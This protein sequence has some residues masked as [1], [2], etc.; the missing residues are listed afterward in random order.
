MVE[1][2]KDFDECMPRGGVQEKYSC[3]FLMALGSFL[4]GLE[5][6]ARRASNSMRKAIWGKIAEFSCQIP[7]RR[8]D[9]GGEIERPLQAHLTQ[10]DSSLPCGVLHEHAH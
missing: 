3:R 10:L 2:V 7:N 8:V 9:R 1:A 4:R 5:S 6:M